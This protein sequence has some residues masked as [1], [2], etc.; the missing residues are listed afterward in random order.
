MTRDW[1][2]A[3]DVRRVRRH[4]DET[5]AQFARRLDVDQVTVAR[6]ETGQR[7]CSGAYAQAIARLDPERLVQPSPDPEGDEAKLSALAQLVHAFF[8][9]SATRAVAALLARERLSDADL[10]VLRRIID[11]Q[12]KTRKGKR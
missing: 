7:R 10:D 3:E 4:L 8:G 6:W 12:K 1:I 11:G 2:A 9:G 5:Q